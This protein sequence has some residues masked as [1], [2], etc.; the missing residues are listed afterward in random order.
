M[1]VS[2]WALLAHQSIW[3]GSLFY[4]RGSVWDT[5]LSLHQI[6]FVLHHC[7]K[8]PWGGFEGVLSLCPFP[9]H[10]LHKVQ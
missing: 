1:S 6:L 8:G 3:M 5:C 7:D 2:H 9:L 4:R 10:A